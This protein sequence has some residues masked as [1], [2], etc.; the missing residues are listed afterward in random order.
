M[1]NLTEA[2]SMLGTTKIGACSHCGAPIYVPTVWF[3][4]GA[5]PNQ[6]TCDCSRKHA[7]D[8][9]ADRTVTYKPDAEER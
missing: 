6:F 3:G 7:T 5:P 4:V 9:S 1:V 2:H 8:A